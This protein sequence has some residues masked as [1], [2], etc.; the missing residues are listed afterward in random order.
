MEE[1]V[2]TTEKGPAITVS[3]PRVTLEI[4]AY[5]PT[6]DADKLSHLLETVRKQF[7]KKA[8]FTKVR[9]LWKVYKPDE[10]TQEEAIEWLIE[11]CKSKYHLFITADTKVK[12]DYI[13]QLMAKINRV[14]DAMSAFKSAGIMVSKNELSVAEQ[15]PAESMPVSP[16]ENSEPSVMSIE[17]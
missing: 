10:M 16:Q 14:Q 13:A 7:S 8:Y 2:K 5:A 9:I 15:L 17:K 12:G 11:R 3:V 4:L 6:K 1:E